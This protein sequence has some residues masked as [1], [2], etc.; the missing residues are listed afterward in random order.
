[1]SSVLNH[2]PFCSFLL[3]FPNIVIICSWHP[4]INIIM[5]PWYS[6]IWNRFIHILTCYWKVSSNLGL[7]YNAY[8]IHLISSYYVGILPPQSSQQEWLQYN[9]KMFFSSFE[10]CPFIY[11]K[12]NMLCSSVQFSAATQS[13][14][15][16]CD[17]MNCSTPGLPVHHPLPESTQTHVSI[18]LVMPS[19]HLSLCLPLLLLP[20]IFASIR[21]SSNESA[22]CIRWPKYWSFSF[23]ISPSNEYSGLI[24]FRMD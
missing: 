22:L 9:K 10:Q 21:V 15:T 1:M 4:T 17:P 2:M 6:I 16:V 14:L 23:N 5:D 13:C 7:Y 12:A 19:N 11:L 3:N 18:E 20:S 24:S 8:I